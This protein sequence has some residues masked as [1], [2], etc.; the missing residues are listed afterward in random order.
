MALGSRVVSICLLA[1]LITAGGAV[2][3]LFWLGGRGAEEVP[4]E[5][6]LE[7]GYS[8]F[9]ALERE[10]YE[11]LALA[12][13]ALADAPRVLAL[14]TPGEESPS[15]EEPVS[16][17]VRAAALDELNRR[18][19][20]LGFAA[21]LGP[22]GETLL[23]TDDPLDTGGRAV[24]P[25]P[26][27]TGREDGVW[28]AEGDLYETVT[29]PILPEMALPDAGIQGYLRVGQKVDDI[30]PREIAKIGGGDVA[31]VVLVR[32][33]A[34]VIAHTLD[35]RFVQPLLGV[36]TSDASGPPLI[37]VVALRGQIVARR[38]MELAGEP[39]VLRLAPLRGSGDP[40]AAAVAVLTPRGAVGGV[41]RVLQLT[42]VGA[43]ALVAVLLVLPLALAVGR[44]GRGPLLE[45]GELVE[46]ARRG[47]V[48]PARVREAGRGSA[49]GLTAS[50]AGLL[51]DQQQ[52]S[53]LRDVIRTAQARSG[54][55]GGAPEP[56]RPKVAL[57]G[58]ELRRHARAS[59]P[60]ESLERLQK[61]VGA[62]RQAV[63]S[64]GGAVEAILGHRVLAVFRGDGAVRRAL[65]AAART[66]ETLSAAETAFDEIEP[67]VLAIA[68][69][70]VVEGYI[71]EE[72][73]RQQPVFMGLPAQLLETVLREAAPGEIYFSRD[74]HRELEGELAETGVEPVAQNGILTPQPLYA[75]SAATAARV[76]GEAAPPEG[77]GDAAAGPSP[78][79][80]LDGR[81]EVR[82][83]VGEGPV[84]TVYRAFDRELGR[85][86]AL[87]MFRPVAI[88]NSDRLTAL[89]S[90]LQSFRGLTHRNVVRLY[91]YGTLEGR[92]FLSR[93]WVEGLDLTELLQRV[94][95]LPPIAALGAARQ[96]T[97]ALAAA[98]SQGL[99]HL[100]LKPGNVLFAAEGSLRVSDFGIAV[101]AP[102]LLDLETA[103]GAGWMAPEQE[104]GEPGDARSDV[105][106]CGL[107][108]HLLIAGRSSGD[109][110]PEL[111]AALAEIIHRCRAAEP[112]QR[113]ADAGELDRALEAVVLD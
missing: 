109:T 49:A 75:L 68:T 2:V 80:V 23:R 56:E 78:G 105:Y 11:R 5:R 92:P 87:K 37:D 88:T 74:V 24:V 93:E 19:W 98:H 54:A 94:P 14:L 72:G 62:V 29:V 16:S 30:W 107:L 32:G 60:R 97:A 31:F 66:L 69:G 67:P 84:G 13:D 28:Y 12:A 25:P 73:G 90:P 89:D 53:T 63:R 21:V 48:T 76:A 112:D 82:G 7:V 34:Q 20:N 17:E 18:R 103:R 1:V 8:A 9:I 79:A 57:V 44:N 61:D 85:E 96:L 6:T 83:P 4:P 33:G 77:P 64:H 113:Y 46:K 40:T 51:A 55:D 58:V 27:S 52:R 101:V 22:D 65:G 108:I 15:V 38:E 104:A 99:T 59:E 70:R 50:L 3:A 47:E 26:N 110:A 81:F 100:R 106:S 95:R 111:P 35:P 36:L 86:V 91:D 43:A 102:P 41:G 10:R 39:W 42:V 71:P 45:L